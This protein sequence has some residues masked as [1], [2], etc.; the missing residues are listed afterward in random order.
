VSRFHTTQT[1]IPRHL[2]RAETFDHFP[3]CRPLDS[4]GHFQTNTYDQRSY[5]KR[6]IV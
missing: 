2:L 1:R 3:N 5:S 4:Y 6:A